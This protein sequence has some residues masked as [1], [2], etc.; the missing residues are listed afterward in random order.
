[1]KKNKLIALFLVCLMVF[2]LVGCGNSSGDQPGSTSPGT[3]SDISAENKSDNTVYQM[4][5]ALGN[6]ENTVNYKA[7]SYFKELVEEQVGDR[8]EITLYPNASICASADELTTIQAG[9]IEASLSMSTVIE[10]FN[11]LEVYL[12]IPFLYLVEDA[13]AELD[14]SFLAALSKDETIQDVIDEAA[15]DVGFKRL[16]VLPA[17]SGHYMMCNTKQSATTIAEMKGLKIR[18]AGGSMLDMY[19]DAFGVDDM[20]IPFTEYAISLQQGVVDGTSTSINFTCDSGLATKYL[21][22][23]LFQHF[24]V[25]FYVSLDWWNKLPEDIQIVLDEAW[26]NTIDYTC[27]FLEE[28]ESEQLAQWVEDAEAEGGKVAPL[29]FDD[30]DTAAAAKQA[31]QDGIEHYLDMCGETGQM[32]LDRYFELAEEYDFNVGQN[33]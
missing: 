19:F 1:M 25:G 3:N 32:I 9:G 11:P 16:G 28:Y 6:A 26:L 7:L 15:E 10:P 2:S 21:T 31:R 13:S 12:S 22:S 20:F 4:G 27:D 29:N 23:T 8:I 18:S 33:L 14:N 30:P 5:I 17:C 24:P